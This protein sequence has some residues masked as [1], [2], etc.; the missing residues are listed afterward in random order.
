MTPKSTANIACS[1]DVTFYETGSCLGITDGYAGTFV[2]TVKLQDIKQK[3][4]TK[5]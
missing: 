1:I 3:F 2:K 5:A 4:V